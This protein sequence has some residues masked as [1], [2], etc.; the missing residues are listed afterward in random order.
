M[1]GENDIDLNGLKVFVAE[2]DALIAMLIEDILAD[3]GCIVVS[4][5]SRL[6]EAMD[7]LGQETLDFDVAILDV[8]LG[9]EKSFPAADILQGRAIPFVFATGSATEDLPAAWRGR[10]TLQKPFVHND[11]GRVLQELRGPANKPDCGS[12]RSRVEP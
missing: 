7:T 10:P 8:H 1:Q 11:V 9:S 2:D 3:Y 12:A 6:D 5:C 4:V